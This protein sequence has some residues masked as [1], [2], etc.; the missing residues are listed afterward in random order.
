MAR[1]SPG[2]EVGMKQRDCQLTG[3]VAER[4]DDIWEAKRSSLS[5]R[6]IFEFG[7]ARLEWPLAPNQRERERR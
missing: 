2:K 1:G 7:E 6:G 5:R 3:E 4:A